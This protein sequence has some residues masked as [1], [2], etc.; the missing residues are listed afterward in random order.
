MIQVSDSMKSST[1]ASQ[2][3]ELHS[4]LPLWC[5]AFISESGEGGLGADREIENENERGGHE[6]STRCAQEFCNMSF[7]RGHF[8]EPSQHG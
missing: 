3:T 8:L 7:A 1:S 5:I 6:Y 4:C 2:I